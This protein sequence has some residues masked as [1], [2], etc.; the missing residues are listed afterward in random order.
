MK[1]DKIIPALIELDRPR[2][3]QKEEL[4]NIKY[5]HRPEVHYSHYGN[6]GCV[7][8]VTTMEYEFNGQTRKREAVY[9]IKSDNAIRHSTGANE[10]IRQYNKHRKYFYKDDSN[11]IPYDLRFELVFIPT[12]LSVKHVLENIEIY[13]GASSMKAY[14]A[15]GSGMYTDNIVFRSTS[16]E[17]Q[18]PFS[19]T[20]TE[21]RDNFK[22]PETLLQDLQDIGDPIHYEMYELLLSVMESDD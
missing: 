11:E 10:I 4:K 12:E 14:G 1:E 18:Q 6:R 2:E 22:N 16:K 17:H 21:Y 9:E 3:F 13:H 15:D 19:P 20:P 5:T 7:D 8:L